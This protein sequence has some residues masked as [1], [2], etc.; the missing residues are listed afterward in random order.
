M[1]IMF[2]ILIV[3]LIIQLVKAVLIII[4]AFIE[5]IHFIDLKIA[6]HANYQFNHFI[7]ELFSQL[8]DLKLNFQHLKINHFSLNYYFK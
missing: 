7:I 1:A 4:Q 8:V 5:L 2:L 6:A 3:Q